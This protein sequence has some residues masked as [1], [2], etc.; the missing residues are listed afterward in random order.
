MRDLIDPDDINIYRQLVGGLTTANVLHGSANPIGGQNTVIKL[1]WGK[2]A[3]DLL[4]KNAPKGIKFALGENIKQPNWTGTNRY[5]QTRMGVEQV[6][7]DA[8]RSPLDY[9]HSNE[10][11]LRNSKIQRTKIPPRGDLELDAMVVLLGGARLVHCHSY[12]P[13]EI[14]MLTRVA[15][16]FGFVLAPFRHVLEGF[17]VAVSLA[18]HGAGASTFS[19]WW[20]F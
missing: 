11:Y 10:N 19:D 12:R 16:D 3:N 9:K 7:R 8:F 15:G 18:G 13:D 20:P 14:F 6:I 1:R 17:S 5:P 2:G 4:F